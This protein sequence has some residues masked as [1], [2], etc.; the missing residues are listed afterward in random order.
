MKCATGALAVLLTAC[1]GSLS[2]LPAVTIQ[3]FNQDGSPVTRLD[4]TGAPIDA[5]DGG[6]WQ[7]P[8]TR[9]FYLYGTAYACGFQWHVAGSPFCGFRVYSSPDAANWTPQGFLF[10]PAAWQTPCG[11]AASGGGCFRP[12]MLFNEISSQYV[13][14]FTGP[15]AAPADYWAMTCGGPSGP[16]SAV[17]GD[18][19]TLARSSLGHPSDINVLQDADHTAYMIYD[20]GG[21]LWIEQLASSYLSSTGTV[22]QIATTEPDIEAPAAFVRGGVYYALYGSYCGYCPGTDTSYSSASKP[23]GP[24]TPGAQLSPNSC[25]GQSSNVATLTVQGQLVYLYE[26]DLWLGT[27]NEAV[28]GRFDAPLSFSGAAVN[29]IVCSASVTVPP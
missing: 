10:D 25:G 19:Q 21:A 26:S 13:L 14:W 28:A 23:L 18:P 1:N 20:A 16:C 12:R 15:G 22:A 3:N 7:D 11:G 2:L 29:P 24:W 5:H 9:A 4:T 27:A 6:I 8:N 17:A